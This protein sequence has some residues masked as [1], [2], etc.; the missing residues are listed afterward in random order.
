MAQTT[1]LV[2]FFFCWSLLVELI[3]SRAYATF[4]L[5]RK[6]QNQPKKSSE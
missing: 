5:K 4:G 1:E 2:S 3:E 6:Q